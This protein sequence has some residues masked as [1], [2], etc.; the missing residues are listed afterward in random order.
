MCF[1]LNYNLCQH[2][3]LNGNYGWSSGNLISSLSIAIWA[4]TLKLVIPSIDMSLMIP[5]ID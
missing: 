1:L 5:C 4:T 3:I 2:L